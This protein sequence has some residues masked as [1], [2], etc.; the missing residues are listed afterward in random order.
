MTALEP[1]ED[2]AERIAAEVADSD[3][4]TAEESYWRHTLAALVGPG[5][6][7]LSAFTLSASGLV[8]LAGPLAV[9]PSFAL[10]E[11]SPVESAQN[12]AYLGIGIG[13]V[14]IALALWSLL[15][16]ES[17]PPWP[18]VVAGAAVTLALMVIFQ[19][20]VVLLMAANAVSPASYGK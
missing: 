16:P 20:A 8:V 14:A 2:P 3:D 11:R 1:T 15:R 17:G 10:G 5:A 18:R 19:Y 7:A 4:G 9:I 12:L 6:L 13:I